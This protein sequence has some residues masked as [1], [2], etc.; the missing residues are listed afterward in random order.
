MRGL[1]RDNKIVSL[2]ISVPD[3]PG[4]LGEISSELGRCGVNIL[5]V[6]HRR[7]YLDVPAKGA[8]VDI[9]IECK[10]RAHVDE[11]VAHLRG[12]GLE[13]HRTSLFSHETG[14]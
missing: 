3:R 13:V 6:E 11:A 1:E 5:E 9:V 12:H 8:V 10:D 4:I 14:G 7:L 2:R